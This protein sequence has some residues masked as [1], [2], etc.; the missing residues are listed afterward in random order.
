MRYAT[1]GRGGLLMRTCVTRLR[2]N[3]G[4]GLKIGKGGGGGLGRGYKRAR[5]RMGLMRMVDELR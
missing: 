5:R 4:V 3:W 2:Y 1:E